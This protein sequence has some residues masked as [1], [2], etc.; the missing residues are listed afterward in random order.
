MRWK[1]ISGL[2][3]VGEGQVTIWAE[4]LKTLVPDAEVLLQYAE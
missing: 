4:Q 2:G 1:K 3:S